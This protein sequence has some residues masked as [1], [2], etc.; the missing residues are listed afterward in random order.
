MRAHMRLQEIVR[1]EILERLMHVDWG[2][3]ICHR[4]VDGESFRRNSLIN[5]DL[6]DDFAHHLDAVTRPGSRKLRT[7]KIPALSKRPKN[8]LERI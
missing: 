8:D 5:F 1:L 3:C 6:N 2:R 7:V 4:L